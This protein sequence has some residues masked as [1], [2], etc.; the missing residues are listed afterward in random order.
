MSKTKSDKGKDSRDVGGSLEADQKAL[1]IRDDLTKVL[2][3]VDIKKVL[4]GKKNGRITPGDIVVWQNNARDRW[5]GEVLAIGESLSLDGRW[6]DIDPFSGSEEHCLRTMETIENSF[7]EEND[8]NNSNNSVDG[9]INVNRFHR[10][11]IWID[12]CSKCVI[13]GEINVNCC[14]GRLIPI[15]L[16]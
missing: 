7:P 14:T 1:L 16:G 13:R 2:M 11:V 15:D 5:R 3:I 8:V 6:G 10:R 12:S 4:S 9:E